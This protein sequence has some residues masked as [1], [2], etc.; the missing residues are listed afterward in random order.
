MPSPRTL[1]IED[2]AAI[3]GPVVDA[4]RAA[5]HEPIAA[6]R[7]GESRG[8]EL[9]GA[10]IQFSRLVFGRQRLSVRPLPAGHVKSIGRG[11]PGA[12]MMIHASWPIQ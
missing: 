9:V 8:E 1:V 12:A 3:R 10:L 2:A 4:L 11:W 5:G 6:A 7:G